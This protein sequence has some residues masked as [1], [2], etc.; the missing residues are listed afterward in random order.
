MF[1]N[2]T[3][4]QWS[5]AVHAKV[6]VSWN[7]HK[8]LPND[9]DFFIS[10][11]SLSGIYGSPGQSNYAAGCSFQDALARYRTMAGYRGSVTLDLGWMSTIGIVSESQ[12]LR[13]YQQNARIMQQVNETDLFATFDHYCNPSLAPL[14]VEHTQVLIGV[15]THE[16]FHLRGETP[17]AYLDRP[18][19]ATF[20]APHLWAAGA[21]SSCAN[22]SAQVSAS[23]LFYKASTLLDRSAIV[24]AALRAKLARSLGIAVG[25]VDPRST[26][27]DYGTDSLMAVE[28]RNWIRNDFGVL[29]AVFEITGGNTLLSIGELVA[30]KAKG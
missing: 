26:P 20:N 27:S 22:W 4:T 1:E 5:E 7:L 13:R 10:L 14:D 6:K 29:I 28:L 30:E 24:V 15:F 11:S 12:A 17:S 25:D 16:N 18:L 21:R 9:M 2:M 3:T 19:F 8:L 23:M